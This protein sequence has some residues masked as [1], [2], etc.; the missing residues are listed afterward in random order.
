[1][2]SKGRTIQE[3][4]GIG[5]GYYNPCRNSSQQKVPTLGMQM[6][7][8]S[9]KNFGYLDSNIKKSFRNSASISQNSDP[10]PPVRGS[11]GAGPPKEH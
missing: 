8:N 6:K 5:Q 3:D 9:W 11:N 1:M 7:E 4:P 2:H 10:Q